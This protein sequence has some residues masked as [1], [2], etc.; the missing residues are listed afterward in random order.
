MVAKKVVAK[1]AVTRKPR[2]PKVK[3]E[4]LVWVLS[5]RTKLFVW[6]PIKG[7]STYDSANAAKKIAEES[8]P[9]S[10]NGYK[11]DRVV[12]VA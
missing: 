1:K 12:V 5:E 4:Q 9:Y 3:P 8:S 6:R 11:V 2:A 10:L 7:Y